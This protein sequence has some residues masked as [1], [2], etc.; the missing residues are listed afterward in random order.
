MR[1]EIKKKQVIGEVI[2]NKMTNAVTIQ[3]EVKKRHPIYKKFV[4]RHKKIKAH[5]TNKDVKIGDT[6]R[7]LETKPISKEIC[8]RVVNIIERGQKG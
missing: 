2:N 5:N 1:S 7:L 4:I 3:L 6:V 8:W